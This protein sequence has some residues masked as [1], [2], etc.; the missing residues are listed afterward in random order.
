MNARTERRLSRR[1]RFRSRSVAVSIA[2]GVVAVVAAYVG[3]EA[4][5]AALSV[6]ALLIAPADLITSVQAGTPWSIT[7]IAALAV[8]GIWSIVLALAPGGRARRELSD[9]RA[10]FVID[11]DVMAGGISRAAAL[12]TGVSRDQ[13]TTTVGRRRAI[14]RVRPSAGF[15]VNADS[16]TDDATRAVAAVTPLRT[17]TIR[18]AVDS[19][20]VLA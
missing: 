10:V 2:L 4:V 17:L 14:V 7:A 12:S 6:P 8:L 18:T 16:A 5:L 9:E 15:P 19:Q 3:V 1:M 11:D 13:V 20:G